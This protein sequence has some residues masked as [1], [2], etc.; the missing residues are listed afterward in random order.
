MINVSE[1]SKIGEA[2]SAMPS[3]QSNTEIL[4]FNVTFVT[5]T[6]DLFLS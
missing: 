1:G 5:L 4:T 6:N 3:R 2:K